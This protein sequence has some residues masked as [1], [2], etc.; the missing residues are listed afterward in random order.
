MR[1][2]IS[3]LLFMLSLTS[4]KD[5]YVSVTGVDT[6]AGTAEQPWASIQKAVDMAQ[7]GDSILVGPGTYC[8]KIIVRQSGL[9]GRYITLRG[10][11]G[12]AGE[13]LT[14]VDGAAR[15]SGWQ[16]APEVGDGAYSLV[17][18]TAAECVTWNG[19]QAVLLAGHRMNNGERRQPLP[20][21]LTDAMFWGSYEQ[22]RLTGFDCL[23]LS[24][25][26]VA[27]HHYFRGDTI[28]FW[29]TAGGVLFGNRE[30]KLY[31]RFVD[32]RNPNQELICAGSGTAFTL[33]DSS[34]FCLREIQIQGLKCG[35]AISGVK[36]TDN[37][38]ED[39]FF[40][41]GS[42]RI[43][44]SKGSSRNVLRNNRLTLDFL[45]GDLISTRNNSLIYLIF[46]YL[47]GPNSSDDCGLS[48]SAAGAGNRVYGNIIYRGLQGIQHSNESVETEAYGN[49][50]RNMASIGIVTSG[51]GRRD[52]HDNI[53]YHCGI[54][55]RFHKNGGKCRLPRVENVYRNLFIQKPGSGSQLFFHLAPELELA[56]DLSLQQLRFYHNTLIGGS[57]YMQPSTLYKLFGQLPFYFANNIVPQFLD[58]SKTMALYCHN[59]MPETPRYRAEL[60]SNSPETV[61]QNTIV[62]QDEWDEI[63]ASDGS[64]ALKENSSA[65]M[66]GLDLS[67]GN[68]PGMEKGYFAG[69]APDPGATQSARKILL[70]FNLLRQSEIL[71]GK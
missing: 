25:E 70:P 19:R 26:T 12:P 8:E 20:T 65:R 9:P 63:F 31:C 32:G 39:N 38:I 55:M 53:I 40:R 66:T 54:N 71:V 47:I 23:M 33:E 1:L 64:Y 2:A 56:E 52:F 34:Y 50:I 67:D 37:I 57:S 22:E 49:V 59:F 61:R 4:A 58:N 16:P 41:H 6:N 36:A 60:V 30:G 11:R 68:W 5:F 51:G 35:L 10:T 13:F 28:P 24:P 7:P 48:F 46:K 27:A 14:I 62:T 43:S 3:C 21:S 15:L 42:R 44:I 69:Q 18:E 29:E 17:L 45:R